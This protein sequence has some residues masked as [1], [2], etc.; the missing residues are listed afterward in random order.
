ML[1]TREIFP[2]A[3]PAIAGFQ[4]LNQHAMPFLC[5]VWCVT[6]DI[7]HL[8]HYTESC[9]GGGKEKI[10]KFMELR[11]TIKAIRDR[12]GWNQREFAAALGMDQQRVST[13]ENAGTTLEIHWAMFVK[14]LPLC[15]E[16]DL[17]REQD[18]LPQPHHESK[19]NKSAREARKVKSAYRREEGDAG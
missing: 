6:S 1:Y 15:L 11:K 10:I 19:R 17:L 9:Q 13:M 2:L 16:L 8:T 3:A 12:K 7:V 14:L 5:N 4:F 18:L